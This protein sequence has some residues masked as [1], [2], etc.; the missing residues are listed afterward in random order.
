MTNMVHA[1]MENIR[2]TQGLNFYNRLNVRDELVDI[3]WGQMDGKDVKRLLE[4]IREDTRKYLE[5]DSARKD[6]TE[7][8]RILVKTRRAR[9]T[10]DHWEYFCNGVEYVCTMIRCPDSDSMFRKPDDLRRHLE[11]VHRMEASK[12]ESALDEGKRFPLYEAKGKDG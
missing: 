10:T 11:D 7:A 1:Q 3:P 2:S 5:S 12:V 8:A 4:Y 6:I 9:A